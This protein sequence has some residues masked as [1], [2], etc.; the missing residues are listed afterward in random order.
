MDCKIR[1]N[2][3]TNF[4]FL[5]NKQINSRSLVS[6]CVKRIEESTCRV[7]SSVPLMHP[8]TRDLGLKRQSQLCACAGLDSSFSHFEKRLPQP[9]IKVH[10]EIR[11]IFPAFCL[12]FNRLLKNLFLSVLFAHPMILFLS[13]LVKNGINRVSVKCKLAMEWY[14]MRMCTSR[15]CPF[16]LFSKETQN[17]FSDALG[18]KV[19]PLSCSTIERFLKLGV[20]NIHGRNKKRN[21]KIR[22]PCLFTCQQALTENGVF[23]LVAR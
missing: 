11:F 17:S 18:F 20:M 16:N 22:A 13:H 7:D 15:L 14:V 9:E 23:S 4:A 12:I 21:K 3:K 1:K 6:G 8:D 10:L 2:P 19:I 5:Y